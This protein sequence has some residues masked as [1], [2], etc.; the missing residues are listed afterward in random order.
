LTLHG[1]LEQGQRE[2]RLNRYRD[3]DSK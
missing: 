1:D 2:T 3:K